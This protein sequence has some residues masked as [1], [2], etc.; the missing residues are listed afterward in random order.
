MT[1]EG[2]HRFVNG[3]IKTYPNT[4]NAYGREDIAGLIATWAMALEDYDDDSV[5][6]AFKGFLISDQK[7]FPPAVGQIVAR[8][9]NK[10][11]I[12]DKALTP[13]EAWVMVLDAM[14]NVTYQPREAFDTLPEMIQ[15]I[16]GGVEA[17][18]ELGTTNDKGRE[19]EKQRFMKE[20]AAAVAEAKAAG[21]SLPDRGYRDEIVGGETAPRPRV[22]RSEDY[23]FPGAIEIGNPS[24]QA[25]RYVQY[26]GYPY[27]DGSW[28][29][30]GAL[31]EK[32]RIEWVRKIGGGKRK[33][34]DSNGH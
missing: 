13:G 17:L 14:K 27:G 16:I 8:I 18:R 5:M 25:I 15:T 22:I 33:K 28:E 10:G 6:K 24:T 20:Y 3:L 19:I 32:E 12:Y 31:S 1:Q 34:E 9:P 2:I 11:G 4:Y 29:E 21:Q 23:W 30:H 26:E 7:G